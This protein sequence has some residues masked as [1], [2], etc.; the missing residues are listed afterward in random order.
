MGKKKNH[1]AQEGDLKFPRRTKRRNFRSPTNDM[2]W[3]KD[4]RY[5]PHNH[6]VGEASPG[7][8]ELPPLLGVTSTK[9]YIGGWRIS[10][11]KP[12]R[13]RKQPPRKGGARS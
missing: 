9:D 5:G 7:G 1:W 11:L 4:I 3:K 10:N 13:T 8:R 12:F 6:R 2:N